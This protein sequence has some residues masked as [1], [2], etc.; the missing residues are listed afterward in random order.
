MITEFNRGFENPASWKWTETEISKLGLTIT[1]GNRSSQNL[2]NDNG[3]KRKTSKHGLTI[4]DRT[5]LFA[6]LTRQKRMETEFSFLSLCLAVMEICNNSHSF[7]S[8]FQTS[9]TFANDIRIKQNAFRL[10]ALC[11]RCAIV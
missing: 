5:G 11:L 7:N 9:I 8:K 6:D 2:L 4:M 10:K 3:R 1:D